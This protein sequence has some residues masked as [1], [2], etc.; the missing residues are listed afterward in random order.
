MLIAITRIPF[1]TGFR[2]QAPACDWQLTMHNAGLSLTKIPHI[3]LFGA[4][5]LFTVIQFDRLDRRAIAWS[6]LST[7]ILG[8]LIELEEGATRTGNCR[9]TDVLPD[10]VGAIIVMLMLLGGLF[11]RRTGNNRS[12]IPDR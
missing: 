6:F 11:I 4:F 1:R 9:L 7:M 2:L 10:A 3:V 12:E 8:L 5:F